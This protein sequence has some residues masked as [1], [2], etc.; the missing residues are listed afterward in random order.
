MEVK[1]F[2]ICFEKSLIA[3]GFAP[4][5]A[6][7]HTLK[8]AKS[9]KDSDKLKI[10]SMQNTSTVTVLADKYAARIKKLS[11]LSV[12]D[13]DNA[14]TVTIARQFSES[15]NLSDEEFKQY[16]IKDTDKQQNSKDNVDNADTNLGI[17]TESLKD[18][19]EEN[20]NIDIKGDRRRRFRS[21]SSTEQR[22]ATQ[23]LDS[24]KDKITK[25]ELTESGKVNYRNFMLTKGIGIW[26]LVGLCTAVSLIVYILISALI[27]SLVALL[28]ALSVIGCVGTLAGLIYGIVKLFSVLPEGLYE[29]GLALVILGITIAAGIGL[30]NLAIRIIPMLWKL[31][32]KFLK[33]KLTDLRIYLN[34]IRTECNGK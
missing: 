9:L 21:K 24:V 33:Q 34:K 4:E 19:V 5:S 30:Y 20:E 15:T 31:F 7:R 22:E 25:V 14:D 23:K 10:K 3:D 11:E 13:E 18:S 32:T 2:L 16:S 27:V 26:A 6:R 12:F 8:I 28:V 17:A 29:I 1:T